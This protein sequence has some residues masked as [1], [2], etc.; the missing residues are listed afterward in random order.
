MAGAA[1]PCARATAARLSRRRA[2]PRDADVRCTAAS[3][4]AALGG[5]GV[6]C[7]FAPPRRAA[8]QAAAF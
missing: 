6:P 5:C 3:R 4:H 2:T 7:I 8:A 1:R